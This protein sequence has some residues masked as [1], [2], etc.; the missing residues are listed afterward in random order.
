MG[1]PSKTVLAAV[2]AAFLAVPEIG[3]AQASTGDTSVALDSATV[4]ALVGLGF[5]IAPVAPGTLTGLEAVFPITGGNLSEGLID[6]SGGLAFTKGGTTTDITD[7]VINL[8]TDILS[9]S[10]N[11]G[12][13]LVPFFDIG[14]GDVLTLNP[15]LAGALT[16]IYGV[17]DLTGATIGTATVALTSVPE[18]STWALMLMGFAGL[19]FASYRSAKATAKAVAA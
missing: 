18:P 3:P 2:P 17:P 13:G 1:V 15:T 6:H 7:F 4:D 8:N 12:S 14:A 11:G 9:G 10:V 16:T 19:G 5:G